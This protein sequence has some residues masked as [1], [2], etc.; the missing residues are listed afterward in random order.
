MNHWPQ[1]VFLALTFIGLLLTVHDHGKPRKPDNAWV[2]L[3]TTAI[4]LWLLAAGGF[5]TGMFAP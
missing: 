3:I 2:T 1:W 4:T 5:F